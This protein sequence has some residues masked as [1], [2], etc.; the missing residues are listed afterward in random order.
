MSAPVAHLTGTCLDPGQ[1]NRD[2][3]GPVTNLTGTCLDLWPILP[4]HAWTRGPVTNPPARRPSQTSHALGFLFL[5][6]DALS[7]TF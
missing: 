4:G 7:R 3:P 5:V 1:S 2:I 6:G